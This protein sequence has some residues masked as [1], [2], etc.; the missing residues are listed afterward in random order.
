MMSNVTAPKAA[1]AEGDSPDIDSYGTPAHTHVLNP[2]TGQISRHVALATAAD[3][4]AAVSAAARAFP[5]WAATPPQTRASVLLRFH[6]LIEKHTDRLAAIIRTEQSQ[7]LSDARDQVIRG[8]DVVGFAHEIARLLEGDVSNGVDSLSFRQ[9]LGVVAGIAPLHF[10]D[11]VP[12]WTW[13]FP[14]TLA[15]GNTFVMKSSAKYQMLPV[16]LG[17]LLAE[18]GLPDGVFH[19]VHGER[20]VAN[21]L[22]GHPQVE[23][24]QFVAST[25]V[26]D[27]IHTTA[28]RIASILRNTRF[29]V[30]SCARRPQR[31]LTQPVG[32]YR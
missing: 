15:C 21:T 6:D 11:I 10:P 2:D 4:D 23:A 25:R 1:P 19:V 27:Y 9:P 29:F 31:A 5:Y 17:G 26:E 8:L 7:V 28:G 20:T 3:V 14:V 30:S 13:M 24:M 16:E 32:E 12:V 22:L 18:A